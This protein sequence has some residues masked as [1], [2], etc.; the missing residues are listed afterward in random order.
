MA[1]KETYVTNGLL[2]M[3]CYEW[4]AGD[5]STN[6]LTLNMILKKSLKKLNRFNKHFKL[7]Y[8]EIVTVLE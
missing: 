6:K 2:K 8:D 5:L 4:Q 7:P 1:K 3:N